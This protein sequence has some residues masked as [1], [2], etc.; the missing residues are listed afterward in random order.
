MTAP[1]EFTF[2]EYSFNPVKCDTAEIDAQ[3]T[4]LGFTQRA[5]HVS[6]MSSIWVQN[7]AI[8][9]IRE[10][11]DVES[12]GITGLGITVTSDV[13]ADV[14][15]LYDADL[16]IYYLMDH[17][18]MRVLLLSLDSGHNPFGESYRLVNQDVA[19][20]GSIEYFSGIL[21]GNTNRDQ[22]DFYQSLGF[23]F[24]KSDDRYNILSSHDHRFNIIFDKENDSAEPQGIISGT[25]D[26]FR[27]QA[28]FTV[29]NLH[30]M[31]FN[32]TPPDLGDITYKVNAYNCFAY[33]N[34]TSHSIETMITGPLPN[35]DLVVRYRKQYLGT[36]PEALD[37]YY[38]KH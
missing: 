17:N 16:D 23:K 13:M 10:T 38:D 34:E 31:N 1:A 20:S 25:Q 33:G 26:I 24:V 11:R 12:P 4:A 18:G 8:I 37:R 19:I 15:P 5:T 14:S 28:K 6:H 35:V 7:Q 21:L 3:L 29:N 2:I 36:K 9:L 32:D 27:A 22:M 30:V